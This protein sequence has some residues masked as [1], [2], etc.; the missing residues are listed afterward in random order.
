M[1]AGHVRGRDAKLLRA[2]RV[3]IAKATRALSNGTEVCPLERLLADRERLEDL[4][5]RLLRYELFDALSASRRRPSMTHRRRVSAYLRRQRCVH[6]RRDSYEALQLRLLR[7]LDATTRSA[8]VLARAAVIQA[9]TQV[10]I[11]AT[12]R[13]VARK[14]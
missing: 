8:D 10:I 3:R 7:S 5:D 9:K 1:S 2:T 12:Q 13:L 4:A 11:E 14:V 6:A